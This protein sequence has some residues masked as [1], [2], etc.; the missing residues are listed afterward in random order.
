MLRSLTQFNVIQFNFR[1]STRFSVIFFHIFCS[2]T[3]LKVS[4]KKITQVNSFCSRRFKQTISALA[5]EKML[6]RR[7][8]Q[9]EKQQ[10]HF[11]WKK[12][13]SC[14]VVLP[15]FRIYFHSSSKNNKN[16]FHLEYVPRKRL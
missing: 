7:N 1:I 14:L 9:F 10:Q 16:T 6:K 12:N 8:E 15:I 3:T 2:R 11:V 13:C 4:L 5:T